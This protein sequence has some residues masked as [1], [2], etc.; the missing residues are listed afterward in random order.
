MR[1]VVE[2]MIEILNPEIAKRQQDQIRRLIAQRKIRLAKQR[3]KSARKA[4]AKAESEL[5]FLM[6]IL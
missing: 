6:G 3:V 2:A 1:C 5:E 4:L